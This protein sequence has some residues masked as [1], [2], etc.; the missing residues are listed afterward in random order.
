MFPSTQMILLFVISFLT[1]P[2]KL[3]FMKPSIIAQESGRKVRVPVQRVGGAD[4]HV[5]K[6][7]TAVSGTDYDGSE[8]ELK[9]DHGETTKT[10]DIVIHDNQV[11]TLA[12]LKQ[13]SCIKRWHG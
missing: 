2:G 3:E 4:G 9:F 8:G 13:R 10:I 7:I 6:D 11:Y 12:D 1:E 5:S